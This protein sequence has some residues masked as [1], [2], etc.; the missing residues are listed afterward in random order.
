MDSDQYSGIMCS[1]C[2]RIKDKELG[3]IA[4]TF[5]GDQTLPGPLTS[6]GLCDDCYAN[7][8]DDFLHISKQPTDVE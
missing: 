4:P 3:W 6:H 7:I 2:G 5:Q 1:W 8:I